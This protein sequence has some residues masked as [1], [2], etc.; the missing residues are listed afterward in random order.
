MRKKINTQNLI[1]FKN[2]KNKKRE[3][4]YYSILNKKQMTI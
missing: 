1:S 3:V 4:T 2:P